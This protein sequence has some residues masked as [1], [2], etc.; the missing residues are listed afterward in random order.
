MY[1]TFNPETLITEQVVM[2][3]L[4]LPLI[5]PM[6]K[7]TEITITLAKSCF[8]VNVILHIAALQRKTDFNVEVCDGIS[9]GTGI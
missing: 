9:A 6:K 4:I 2:R 3:N 8:C 5:S 7:Q 1:F